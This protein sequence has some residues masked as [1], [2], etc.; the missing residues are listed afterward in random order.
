MKDNYL[1]TFRKG[2]SSFTIE[3]N[4]RDSH[5]FYTRM[6]GLKRDIELENNQSTFTK[7]SKEDDEK[8]ITIS[9]LTGHPDFDTIVFTEV[10][11][12]EERG[13]QC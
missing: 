7:D 4:S 1:I 6:R 13:I 10:I 8:F 11:S 2:D 9:I 12:K 5:L 3:F